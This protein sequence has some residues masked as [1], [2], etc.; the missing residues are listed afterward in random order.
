MTREV[1]VSPEAEDDI[2][3]VHDWYGQISA[4]F[5]AA[6]VRRVDEGPHRQRRVAPASAPAGTA[7][8]RRRFDK[9]AGRLLAG[10]RGRRR[11]WTRIERKRPHRERRVVEAGEDVRELVVVA[12][13]A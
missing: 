4:A 8:S 7:A 9:Q 13:G 2:R 11:D 1:I 5:A 10:R 6:F 3:S 12:R